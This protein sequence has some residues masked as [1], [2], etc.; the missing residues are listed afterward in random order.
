[1]ADLYF[2]N[3]DTGYRFKVLSFDKE[4]GTVTMVGPQNMPFT[5]PYSVERFKEMRYRPVTLDAP[6][7]PPPGAAPPPPPAAIVVG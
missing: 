5:E 3:I 7:P 1:M 2:E 4:K 6:P